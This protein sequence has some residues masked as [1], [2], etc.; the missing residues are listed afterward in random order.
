MAAFPGE[1]GPATNFWKETKL[2][3]NKA[4]KNTRQW[5]RK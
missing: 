5:E 2:A 4:M 1:R 3:I